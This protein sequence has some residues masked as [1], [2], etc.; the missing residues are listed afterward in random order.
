MEIRR[1]EGGIKVN[2]MDGV[3]EGRIKGCYGVQ[4]GRV[5]CRE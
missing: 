4:E 5:G 3:Q 2:L 1:V